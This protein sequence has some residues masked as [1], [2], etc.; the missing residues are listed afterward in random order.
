MS[1]MKIGII[2]LGYVGLPLCIEFG[3]KYDVVGFDI[4]AIR[5]KEL[6]SCIDKTKEVRKS[7]LN[8]ILQDKFNVTFSSNKKDLK[9][10][11]I[12]IVTVPTPVTKEKK[13]DLTFLH[14]ASSLVG[15]FLK[16]G[17]I[18]IY[19]STVFPGSLDE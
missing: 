18:V 12:Y 2:G 17:N 16:K 7:D 10:V 19:E 13:P 9:D 14:N 15:S 11:D 6:N 3:K 4:N 1:D 5:V 8:H